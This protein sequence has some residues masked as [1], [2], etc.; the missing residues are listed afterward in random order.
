MSAADRGWGPGWPNCQTGTVVVLN[1][2][3]GRLKIPMRREITLPFAAMVAELEAEPDG[4]E[5]A[6]YGTWGGSCRAIGGSKVPS[7]H[8][9]WLAVDLE[10][11]S[12]PYL[13]AAKHRQAHSLRKTYPGNKVI[14]SNMPMRVEAIAAKWGFRWGGVYVNKPDPM[15]FEFMGTPGQAELHSITAAKVLGQNP[16]AP[17]PPGAKYRV[18]VQGL[19]QNGDYHPEVGN[20]QVIFKNA[21]VYSGRIDNVFGDQTEAAA[22]AFQ[23]KLGFKGSQV[24]GVIGKNTKTKT[25]AL[26]AYLRALDQAAKVN[27]AIERTKQFQR[28]V[29]VKDD[30]DFGKNTTAAALA[31]MVGWPDAVKPSARK[32]LRGNANKPLVR[33]LQEQGVR[34]GWYPAS[35]LDSGI[36]GPGVNH[37][38]VVGL[39]QSDSICGPDGFKNAVK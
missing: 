4:H 26:F 12:N 27:P 16:A 5:F 37:I 15:H 35:A 1:I 19:L 9:W 36:T 7:N 24:D 30:G 3:D 23:A 20:W 2:D 22:K 25:E 14:R 38:I 17:T 28:L 6:Q 18:K 33:W 32:S 10:A 21:G 11:P 8:S 39:K 13:S 31:N 29:G 34:R